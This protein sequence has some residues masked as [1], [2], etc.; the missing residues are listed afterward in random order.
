ME[1]YRIITLVDITR[2]KASRSETDKIKIGQQANFNSLLQAIGIRANIDWIKDP[3]MKVG[4][5]PLPAEGHAAY[6]VWDFETER[7]L[8]YATTDDPVG[9]LKTDL[10][11][12]PIV[13]GLNNTEILDPAIFQV[14]GP[15]TNIWI[16]ELDTFE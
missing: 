7:D 8:V 2:S 3:H 11:G 14:R 4:R 9:L 6:W 16:S 5:L 15:K 13:D 1:R 12:V 10:H